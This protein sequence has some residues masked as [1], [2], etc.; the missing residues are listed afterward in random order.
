VSRPSVHV[1]TSPAAWEV[2]ASSARSEI[3]EAIRILGPRSIAEISL[4]LNRPADTLYRHIDMLIDAG[5]VKEA[6]YRKGA[7]NVER[8]LDVVADDFRI[9]FTANAGA[10]E[11]RAITN[12][13]SSFLRAAERT[14][15][16]SARA[17]E[18]NFPPKDR[19]ISIN[20]E[21][22]WLTPEQFQEVRALI[23]KLKDLMD[24]G[25]RLREG[26]L[27]MTLTIACPVTRKRGAGR[28]IK[29]PPATA[30]AVTPR[31]RKPRSSGTKP[32]G[33]RRSERKPGTQAS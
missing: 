7:R 29:P 30:K 2:L 23:R 14:V 32:S 13:A 1:V 3:A 17:R 19:N 33:P 22:S 27:Y 18:L 25:K 10:A 15:R 11:N 16:D 8:L 12:T 5:F 24:E 26:R 6:G 4:A 28:A 9:E 20:Y 21:L 31:T